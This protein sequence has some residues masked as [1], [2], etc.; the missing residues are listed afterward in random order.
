MRREVGVL[1]IVSTGRSEVAGPAVVGAVGIR[2]ADHIVALALTEAGPMG[3]TARPH[4][5]NPHT[6]YT[7]RVMGLLIPVARNWI[8]F[9]AITI[10]SRQN[11]PDIPCPET[12]PSSLNDGYPAEDL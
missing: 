12:P 1:T 9:I 5:A 7:N 8:K 4:P 10:P 3:R 11:W 2:A 6:P